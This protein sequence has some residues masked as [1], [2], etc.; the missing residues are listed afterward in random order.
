[1]YFFCILSLVVRNGRLVFLLL[2]ISCLALF[3]CLEAEFFRDFLV[4]SKNFSVDSFAILLIF[5]SALVYFFLFY[6]YKFF[7][8]LSLVFA[9]LRFCTSN[10]LFFFI[11][12]EL[13][14]IPLFYVIFSGGKNPE[15]LI[16]GFSLWIYTLIG[17]FPLLF[18][19]VKKY[20]YFFICGFSWEKITLF[21]FEGLFW[22]V[23][24][25][26]K[27]PLFGL[28][29]WLP[30]A[31]VE[32]PFY[33]SVVLAAIMLKL[34]GYG[35]FRVFVLLD[36]LQYFSLVLLRFFIL[37]FFWGRFLCLLRRDIKALIA[38][39]RIAHMN[40]FLTCFLFNKKERFLSGLIILLSHGMVSGAL[41]FLFNFLYL[42]SHRRSYFVNYS[43]GTQL[44]SFVLVWGLFCVLNSSVPP[45][46][47]I[48]AEIF[49]CSNLFLFFGGLVIVIFFVGFL[50]CGLF[51]I[52]LFLIAMGGGIF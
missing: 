41:F 9:I 39:S 33:G 11:F 2:V 50:L 19:V 40:F 15:R 18:K 7:M 30:L 51:R 14:I 8:R 5:L 3:W 31:H 21:S 27:T 45:N 38:Y 6:C 29:Q 24:F 46:C 42:V 37:G 16:S 47:A 25:L 52:Y 10:F 32:A 44:G 22:I 1:M 23:A 4:F 43:V 12:F 34:G 13:S 36:F 17:G 26:I 35:L 49:L 20:P 48:L 28:H